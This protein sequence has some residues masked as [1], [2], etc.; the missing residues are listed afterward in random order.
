MKTFLM[1]LAGAALVVSLSVTEGWARGGGGR[2]GGGGGGGG[3][4]FA[5]GGGARS[6]PSPS[7]NRGPSMSRAAPSAAISRPAPSAAIS[8]PAPSAAISRPAVLPA[9]R[10]ASLGTGARPAQLPGAPAGGAAAGRTAGR[11]GL[12]SPQSFQ[13][14][15]AGDVSSFLNLPQQP[16]VGARSSEPP[17]ASQLPS[18]GEGIQSK[19]YTTAGGTTITIAGG[20]G[21]GTTQGGATVGGAGAAIKVEGAGGNTYV[22]GSG[23]AGASKGDSAA[24]AAGSRSGVETAAGGQAVHG[25]GVRAATDGTNTAVRAGS[26]TAVRDAQGN[27]AMNVRGGYADSSGYRQGGSLTAA[28]NQ[29]GYTAANVRGGYGAGGTGQ[30]GSV[31]GIRGPGGNVVTAGR[32][33]SFVNGQFVGGQA[34]T[35]VNGAYTRWGCFTPGWYGGYPHAWWPGKWA[36]RATAWTAV[37]W[38]TAG[39]YCGCSGEGVYYDYG[40][41]VV[42]DDDTVYYGE[43]AVAS[44]EQYYDQASQQADAGQQAQN[45]DWLPLGVFAVIADPSQTQTEKVVQLAVNKDGVIRGNFQDFVTDTVTPIVG[46]VDKQTQRVTFKLEGNDSLVVETGLYNL[47]NDE[48]PVLIHLGPDRQESRTLIRLANPE[49]Q[50]PQPQQPASQPASQPQL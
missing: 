18:S 39:A 46:A 8:R 6:M 45:E 25:S 33:A 49:E 43:E 3:G 14:P 32:G 48:V 35:A 1:L 47:T 10:P 37:A 19:S 17:A 13:R 44:A 12:Q 42:Y 50:A 22:K 38:A 41:N 31:S 23:V 15:S 36:V 20:A 40:D 30:V 2:V 29:W 24:F 16:Q 11:P 21:S 5:G 34:W 27:A 4:G 7:I 26:G 28:R 9:G